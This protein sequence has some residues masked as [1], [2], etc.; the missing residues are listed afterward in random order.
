M[1]ISTCIQ[2]E[3]LVSSYLKT[4]LPEAVFMR[5]NVVQAFILS[6]LDDAFVPDFFRLG[7]GA[8]NPQLG[9]LRR[10]VR[11]RRLA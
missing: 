6:I 8:A 9:L 1:Y 5:F 4:S 7:T 3:G 10:R 2:K 11:L